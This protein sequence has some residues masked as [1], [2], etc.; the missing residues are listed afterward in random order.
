MGFTVFSAL[1]QPA[2]TKHFSA[3]FYWWIRFFR[4]CITF[5]ALRTVLLMGLLLQPAVADQNPGFKVEG[6]A[7]SQPSSC[8]TI[9]NQASRHWNSDQPEK[10]PWTKIARQLV[11]YQQ[12][13]FEDA[14]FLAFWGS[15]QLYL[16]Q[17]DSARDTLERALM[18]NPAQG[19]AQMDYAQVLYLQGQPFAALELNQ[20]LLNEPKLPLSAL[21]LLQQRQQRWLH[22]LTLQQTQLIFGVGYDSNLNSA[23]D[24]DLLELTLSNGG[25]VTLPLEDNEP[26]EAIV[27]QGAVH[28]QEK[29][30]TPT[31]YLQWQLALQTEHSRFPHDQQ[32]LFLGVSELTRHSSLGGIANPSAISTGQLPA[33]WQSQWRLGAFYA[34]YDQQVLYQGGEAEI[35]IM[36][37]ISPRCQ[38]SYPVSIQGQDYPDAASQNAV[39]LGF[40]PKLSCMLSDALFPGGMLFSM[41]GILAHNFALQD[42]A[43]GDQRHLG[44]DLQLQGRAGKGR[45]LLASRWQQQQD[46]QGYSPLLEDNVPRKNELIRWQA[47]YRYPLGDGVSVNLMAQQ[48]ISRSN[49]ALFQYQREQLTIGFNWQLP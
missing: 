2:A 12:L 15:A 40:T 8:Q 3:R 16:G 18:L 4:C 25:R 48:Q 41:A 46:Y 29:K 47:G 22:A 21:K 39:Q 1:L 38:L 32:Q 33:P 7:V 28:H 14:D 23:A 17:L 24:L 36:Q 26:R 13:C 30:L 20:T 10:S 45:W 35:E 6:R 27:L 9:L 31:G 5:N 34:R 19:L 44:V 49:L 42:R 11:P 43:G 37:A